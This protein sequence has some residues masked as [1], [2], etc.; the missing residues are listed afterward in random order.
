[1]D[2]MRTFLTEENILLHKEYMRTLR[3]RHSIMEKSTPEIRNKSITDIEKM[4][5]PSSVK[6]EILPNYREFLA[7]ELYFKSFSSGKLYADVVKKYYSSV[8]AFLYEI[9]LV[10]LSKSSGFIFIFLDE[11]DKIT[12][13]HSDDVRRIKLSP[14][15]AIDVSEHAYFLDYRFEK[16]KYIRSAISNLNLSMLDNTEKK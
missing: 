3:L 12:I 13:L 1:M 4:R 5:L 14:K 10:A 7:H 15:L 2:Q 16:D 6:D 8:E 9:Y 11:R